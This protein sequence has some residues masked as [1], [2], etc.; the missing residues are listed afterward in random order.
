MPAASEL[1][2]AAPTVDHSIVARHVR[3]P[4]VAVQLVVCAILSD[5]QD[6]KH[7]IEREVDVKWI[8]SSRART[9]LYIQSKVAVFPM[10]LKETKDCDVVVV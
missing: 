6:V 4:S 8:Q 5:Q 1:L 3:S 9:A 2:N 7:G 10:R